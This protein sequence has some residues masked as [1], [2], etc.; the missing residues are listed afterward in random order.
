LNQIILSLQFTMKIREDFIDM[1]LPTLDVKIWIE[2]VRIEFNLYEKPMANN[3]VLLA[4]TAQSDKNKFT[5]LTQE[6]VRRLLHTCTTLS[7]SQRME[8]L[9]KV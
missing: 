8:N 7:P 5:S 4:R 9:G 2:S 6:V 1:K 3:M